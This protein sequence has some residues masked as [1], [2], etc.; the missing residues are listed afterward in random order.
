MYSTAVIFSDQGAVRW[1]TFVVRLF[2]PPLRPR[3]CLR[4]CRTSF[5]QLIAL[6]VQPVNPHATNLWNLCSFNRVPERPVEWGNQ[7][8]GAWK[9]C[10]SL[11]RQ[12]AIPVTLLLYNC[13]RQHKW[14][15]L[16][17]YIIVHISI[18]GVACYRLERRHTDGGTASTTLVVDGGGP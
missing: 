10:V 8:W 13:T 11:A 12:W 9:I 5:S 1:E 4:V 16:Q 6:V 18:N 3:V 17:Y 7:S 14:G 2:P 15:S